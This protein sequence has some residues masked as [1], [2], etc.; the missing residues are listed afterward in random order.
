MDLLRL[1]ADQRCAVCDARGPLLCAACRRSLSWLEGPLCPRCGDPDPRGRLRCSLCERLG[2]AVGTARSAIAHDAVGGPIVRAWKD[3]A[4]APIARLAADCV[5]GSI[6]RPAADV[7]VPVPPARDRAAWRGVDGP[8]A[9][10]E[11]VGCAWGIPVRHD[12]LQRVRDRPQRGL[13]ATQRRRN[14]TGSFCARRDVAGRVVL[15]DDVLTTGATVRA[16]ARR[17][18][19]AGAYRVDVVTF[20]RVA[21]IA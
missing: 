19:G 15:I 14:A 8:A 6:V 17:L 20:A 13:T 18:R 11:H 10:A 7:I 4:R 2:R 9:L 1:L 21:T 12:V 16:A 3:A 5:V